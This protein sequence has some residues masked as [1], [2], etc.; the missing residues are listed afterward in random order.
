MQH[1]S[2]APV[3]L[4]LVHVDARK[5]PHFTVQIGKPMKRHSSVERDDKYAITVT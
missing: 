3:L 5:K 1:T 4:L 2:Y